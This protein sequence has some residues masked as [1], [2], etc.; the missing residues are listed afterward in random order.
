MLHRGGGGGG[1]RGICAPSLL[2]QEPRKRK[3][4]RKRKGNQADQGG[5]AGAG[6]TQCSLKLSRVTFHELAKS[7]K[8]F[9]EKKDGERHPKGFDTKCEIYAVFIENV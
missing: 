8:I 4:K 2:M 1:D 9:E 6:A 7:H 3:R 5:G